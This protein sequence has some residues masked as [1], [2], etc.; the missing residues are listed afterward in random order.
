MSLR[1]LDALQVPHHIQLDQSITPKQ[2]SYRPIPVHMKEAFQQEIDKM[3]K[4]GVLKPV[5]EATQWIN[6]FVLVEWKDK[7]GNLKLRICLDPINLNKVIVREPYHFKI[8]EDFAHLL[9]DACIMSVCDCKKGC[10]YWQHDEVSSFCTTFNTE[11]GRP[12]YTVMPFGMIVVGDEFHCKLDQCFGHIKQVIVIADHIMIVGK[13][14]NHNHHDK[15]LTTLLETAR[16]CNVQLNYE[17]LQYEKQE[18]DFCMKLRPQAVASLIRTNHNNHQDACPH[19]QEECIIIYGNGQLLVQI[20]CWIVRDCGV[21]QRVSKGKGTLQL[22]P[23]TSVFLY[24]VK[25]WDCMCS[26][27]GLLY[28]WE[29]NCLANWCK[30][31]R[32]RCMS[33]SRRKKSVYFAS[34]ALTDAQQ[35]Y[36]AIQLESLAIAWAMEKFLHFLYASHFILETKQKPL[37]TV[38]S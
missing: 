15:A 17:R 34:K 14:P 8:P 26:H 5:C 25:N 32:F 19:K 28:S 31:I 16:R 27:I 1:V 11:L 9:A 22:G 13:K 23:R 18:V 21:H 36:V 10:W 3:L 37:E 7:L 24:T 38:L 33:S 4:E 29:T 6:S 30:H 35:G 20:F 2:T 12:R